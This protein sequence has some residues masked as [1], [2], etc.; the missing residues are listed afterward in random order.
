[1]T[2]EVESLR[3]E[4]NQA[5]KRLAQAARS[6]QLS[7]QDRERVSWLKGRIAELDETRKDLEQKLEELMGHLP[8]LPDERV[9]AGGKE[10]NRVVK[11]WGEPT[12]HGSW[13]K[14][15]LDLGRDLGL[16]D[17]ERGVKLGGSGFWIYTGHGAA[18]EWALLN[19]FCSK[20]YADGYQFLLPPHLLL[21]VC[22]YA[23]GQFPKFYDDVFHLKA[24]QGEQDR[25]LLPTSETSI[26]NM[27]RDEILDEA[28][29]PIKAFAYTPC[30]RREAGGAR[31]DER[32]TVR[33]HQFNKVEMFQFVAREDGDRALKELVGRAETLLEELGLHYRTVLLGRRGRRCFHGHHLRH[34][35]LAAVD[36]WLQRG[37]QRVV[38]VGL[39]GPSGED[40]LPSPRRDQGEALGAH[41]ERVGLG[42]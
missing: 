27:Y 37:Q 39:P 17:L 29:L 20:H 8:N 14:N 21:P 11:I 30:Y 9:P 28:D 22:G 36:R 18:L 33:G 24:G 38:G 7:D 32:G 16:V 6:G 10:N 12:T 2:T 25:F 1:M 23:A 40:P 5:A 19:Y 26:L 13:A 41:A 4:R 34:R 3:A 15:H 35:G 42:D 31:S